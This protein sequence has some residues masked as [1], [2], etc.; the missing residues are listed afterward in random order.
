[1]TN[2]QSFD[3][4]L[5]AIAIVIVVWVFA[6]IWAH[7]MDEVLWL[8]TPT[9]VKVIIKHIAWNIAVVF[10]HVAVWKYNFHNRNYNRWSNWL[11]REIRSEAETEMREQI[12]IAESHLEELSLLLNGIQQ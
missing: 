2:L 3:L 10:A 1:M 9:K 11:T 6:Q 7:L 4:F 12:A 5:S 8:V